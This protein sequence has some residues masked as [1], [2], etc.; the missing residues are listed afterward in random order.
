MAGE[1]PIADG[2]SAR[3]VWWIEL[4][5]AHLDILEIKE[6]GKRGK[7]TDE[8]LD[9][10]PT[11]LFVNKDYLFNSFIS[12]SYREEAIANGN[13]CRDNASRLKIYCS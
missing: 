2:E 12:Y 10:S 3:F 13:D 1:A 11:R 4:P 6:Q 8:E 7:N 9:M 5:L